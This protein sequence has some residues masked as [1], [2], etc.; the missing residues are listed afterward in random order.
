MDV[1]FGFG[2]R[3]VNG[4]AVGGKV[5]QIPLGHLTAAGI[6]RAENEDVRFVHG[7]DRFPVQGLSGRL[8]AWASPRAF[9][10]GHV[11]VARGD[12]HAVKRGKR[13]RNRTYLSTN[14]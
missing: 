9:D 12:A 8:T 13:S 3:A 11:I 7:I 10:A 1:A 6:P 4:K 2:S 5:T 14:K